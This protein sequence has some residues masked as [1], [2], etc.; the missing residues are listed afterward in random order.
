MRVKHLLCAAGIVAGLAP[1]SFG[2]IT[3]SSVRETNFNGTGLDRVVL[4]GIADAASGDIASADMTITAGT[5]NGLKFAAP[6]DTGSG[7]PDTV[8]V[9]IANVVGASQTRGSN[10]VFQTVAPGFPKPDNRDTANF[11]AY[12]NG[13]TTFQIAGFDGRNA[14]TI[15]IGLKATSAQN[16][17]NGA[18]IFA[19]VV[20]SGTTVTFAGSAGGDVVGSPSAPIAVVNEGTVVPEPTSLCFLGLVGAGTLLRR[21]RA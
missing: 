21:R 15:D 18:A 1:A 12:A 17:G 9:T 5:A 14:G 8:P 2:A 4:Y 6:I 11:P 19:A 20:P 10:V 13:L 16:N 7:E 3:Y